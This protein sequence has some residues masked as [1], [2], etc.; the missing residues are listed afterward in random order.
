MGSGALPANTLIF[1]LGLAVGTG[2]L[3]IGLLLGYWFGKKSA[4]DIVDRQQ[5]LLFLRNLSTWTSEFA[6]D[7]SKY[8]TELDMLSRRVN[9]PKE[10]GKSE[11]PREEVSGLL[12]QIMNANQQ[13]QK[14][15]DD[16][17]NRLESQTQQISNY[18]TEARTDGLTGLLNRRAFDKATDELFG[19]WTTKKQKFSLGLVDIDHFKQINDTY[20][21]PAG[22]A[23]L[24]HVARVLQTELRDAVCVAR[25]G[26]EEFAVLSL[27]S[28]EQTANALDMLRATVGKL[29]ILHEDKKITVT[30]SGGAA[31]V[32]T[33]E[34]LGK[35]VRRTDDALYAAKLGGRNRVYLHDGVNSVLISKVAVCPA[36]SLADAV[37]VVEK[38]S[39]EKRVQERL[40]RIVEDES[41]RHS[42][43]MQ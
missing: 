1:L 11:P 42:N 23:V 35:L 9:T 33:D 18:L 5:F 16:A 4:P 14:R 38:S 8:Q 3:G 27:G 13:L 10:S 20:G 40:Q 7:V 15:L 22:D 31:E 32:L 39:A 24:K 41:R 19:S 2:L 26:G 6:G 17:E 28:A 43:L 30:L 29:E 36:N 34:K 25:Y 37:A 21:H 12:S